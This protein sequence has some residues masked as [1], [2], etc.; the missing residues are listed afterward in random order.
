M[1]SKEEMTAFARETLGLSPS[2]EGELVPL[3]GRGSDRSY[4]RFRRGRA[5]SAILVQ[6]RPERLENSRFAAIASFLR[7]IKIPV[8]RVLRHDANKRLIL[9]E[10]LGDTDLWRLR[11]EP[12]EIRR[13]LYRETLEIAQRL[14]SYPLQLFPSGRVKLMES[15]GPALYGWERDYFR[16]N[17]VGSLCGIVLE[18]TPGKQLEEE[19]AGLADRL[20]SG[21][22]SLVHRDLQSQNVMICRQEPY[23]IDFQGMRFGNPL[24]DVGSLLCDPYVSFSTAERRELL[25]YY[26]NLSKQ[27]LDWEGFQ[28]AFWEAA[29]QRLMQALGAYG[30]LGLIKGLTQYLLHVPAGLLNLRIAAENAASL[31]R[32][33][34]LCARCEKALAS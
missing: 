3:S 11:N 2:A 23:L 32:L 33:R 15:F 25:S 31:P 34:A 20:A 13:T 5:D 24:Y 26:Y 12:W 27:D 10:D 29:A 17:F 18:T 19:L 30:F 28:N 16:D 8:P 4:F 22:Q 14:H 7:E 9:M 21:K 1:S 6:Y